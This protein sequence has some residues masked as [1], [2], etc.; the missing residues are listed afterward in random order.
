MRAQHL[1]RALAGDLR[2]NLPHLSLAGVGIAT[3]VGLL[4]LLVALGLQIR[5]VVL[6][7]VV[8]ITQL[9]VRPDRLD[10]DVGVLRLG[11]GSDTLDDQTVDRLQ[12]I[13]GVLQVYPKMELIAP[14]VLSGGAGLLGQNI[15]T[16]VVADGIPPDLV[17]DVAPGHTFADPGSLAEALVRD[18]RCLSDADCPGVQ[19]CAATGAL[20]PPDGRGVCLEPVPALVSPHLIE[21]FNGTV[22]RAYGFPALNPQAAVGLT[23]EVAVGASSFRRSRRTATERL[24]VQL[25][26]FSDKAMPLGLTLPIETVRR[27]NRH[28]GGGR[29]GERYHSV[30]VETR[31]ASE[32]GRVA[33]AVGD[34]GLEVSDR[35]SLRAASL[36][37]VFLA[38]A[39][40]LGGIIVVGSAANVMHVQLL[41]VS[42]RRHEIA[43]LRALGASRRQIQ[44][45][46]VAEAAVLGVMAGAAGWLGALVLMRLGD[47]AVARLLPPF[48][49]QPDTFFSMPLW[50][51][52]AAVL[53]AVVF[54]AGGA[55]LPA[56][57]AGRLA[58]A[59]T[60]ADR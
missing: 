48:P 35:G 49:Y 19:Y 18:A 12:M 30:I 57:R 4:V 8:P 15:V 17:A 34:L 28:F 54:C 40:L 29:D 10:V 25:V 23:A 22:R 53:F 58:P 21:I 39:G 3:G 7:R 46:V 47:L 13:P 50:L 38:A 36:I 14:A 37:S 31:S 5:E 33:E 16:E 52:A 55:L 60:L 51:P 59:T 27:L 2:R 11:L 41:M 24:R 6:H 56:T 44:T 32:V 20:S 9:E 42:V 26:G 1:L 43:L 45:L